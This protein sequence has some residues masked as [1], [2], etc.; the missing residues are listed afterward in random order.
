[1]VWS[2]KSQLVLCIHPPSEILDTFWPDHVNTEVSYGDFTVTLEKHIDLSHCMEF[3]LKLSMQGSDIV[4]PLSLL[5]IKTSWGKGS[6]SQI[7]GIA[8]NTIDCIRK[9]QERVAGGGKT[10]PVI[11][12]S[13]TGADR[14]GCIAVAI[15]AIL[16]TQS[17]RPVLIN[18]V[19]A[20]YRICS[21][22]K[23]ALEDA[24]NILLSYKIVLTHGHEL[25]NRHGIMT[26]YQMKT[27]QTATVEA[28]EVTA[29]PLSQLDPL[30]KLK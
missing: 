29:D 15:T 21:Q 8:Q 12:N 27:A 4:H 13:L 25:L 14:S 7:L 1:M 17:R 20:W 23:G 26:S 6:C 24:E 28:K 11:M 9:L 30:W 19:D 22:R 2:Q 5:Q 10:W 18:V 3:M 16:A